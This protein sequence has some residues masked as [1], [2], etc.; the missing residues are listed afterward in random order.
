MSWFRL[1]VRRTR[2]FSLLQAGVLVLTGGLLVIA[3]ASWTGLMIVEQSIDP[4]QVG[5][6]AE[7]YQWVDYHVDSP[8]TATGSFVT[9]CDDNAGSNQGALRSELRLY[10][11][12]K[13]LGPPHSPPDRI[14]RVGAGAY[15]YQCTAPPWIRALTFSTSDN[16]DPRSNG[17]HYLARYPVH[18]TQP[19]FVEALSL[20]MT[21]ILMLGALGLLRNVS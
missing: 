17:R 19:L 7:G 10:E 4:T 21:G 11:N 13:L 16:S 14:G 2:P 8:L 9:G 6:G 3:F 12:G 15:A 20:A 5:P 1:S 18:L